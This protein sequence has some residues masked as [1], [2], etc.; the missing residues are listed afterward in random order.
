MWELKNFIFTHPPEDTDNNDNNIINIDTTANHYNSYSNNINNKQTYSY[1]RLSP[2]MPE[3][4]L[5][6]QIN[7]KIGPVHCRCNKWS[8]LSWFSCCHGS[9]GMEGER[10]LQ[11]C[12]WKN[13]DCYTEICFVIVVMTAND[14]GQMGLH[15]LRWNL[16]ISQP[17]RVST[18]PGNR[19]IFEKQPLFLPVIYFEGG[20]CVRYIFDDTGILKFDTGIYIEAFVQYTASLEKKHTGMWCQGMEGKTRPI[21]L[22][23]RCIEARQFVTLK[24]SIQ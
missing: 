16:I 12:Q 3:E 15:F 18:I 7:V 13:P 19:R 4:F 6:A 21:P 14:R 24:I 23:I 10:S 9:G 5:G 8:W 11:H 2:G 22:F 17:I 20:G 1:G